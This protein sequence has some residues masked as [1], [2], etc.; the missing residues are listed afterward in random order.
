[1]SK[2]NAMAQVKVLLFAAL[3]QDVVPQAAKSN[4]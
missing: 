3:S 1:M 4:S 2:M